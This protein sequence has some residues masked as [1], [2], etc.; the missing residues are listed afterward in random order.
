MQPV[1]S[2][3]KKQKMKASNYYIYDDDPVLEK[4]AEYCSSHPVENFD[5]V[6]E[7]DA[8]LAMEAVEDEFNIDI[9]DSLLDEVFSD[10]IKVADFIEK[11]ARIS[12]QREKSQA[13]Q[14]RMRN[15]AKIQLAAQKRK[16]AIQ[17]G[18]HRV[19]KRVG[20]AAG[21]YSFVEQPREIKGVNTSSASNT[22]LKSKHNFD[23]NKNTS[24]TAKTYHLSKVAEKRLMALGLENHY[25]HSHN[26][27]AALDMARRDM[28]YY[29][30]QLKTGIE[31]E[32]GDPVMAEKIALSKLSH[33]INHYEKLANMV[34]D[35]V[36]NYENPIAGKL[37]YPS[38]PPKGQQAKI[39]KPEPVKMPK[40]KS[41]LTHNSLP[42]NKV[43]TKPKF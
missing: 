13:K 37:G 16:R 17:A 26:K 21:G 31:L 39:K 24:S 27:R 34:G 33:D 2:E 4:V 42:Q 36:K 38:V 5:W 12:T 43:N 23:P 7:D 30:R 32:G 10:E 29:R 25:R 9:P 41:A 3:R 28:A 8:L 1:N 14:Y 18:S 40:I 6:S 11:I 20:S 15:K 22:H 19:K 35:P